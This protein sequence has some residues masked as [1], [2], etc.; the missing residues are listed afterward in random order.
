MAEPGFLQALAG[1][2][3]RFFAFVGEALRPD[4]DADGYCRPSIYERRHPDW[5]QRGPG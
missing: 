3:T 5:R 4:E 2:A 1:E